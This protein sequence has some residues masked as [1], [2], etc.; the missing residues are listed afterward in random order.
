VKWPVIREVTDPAAPAVA[1]D[2]DGVTVV[3]VDKNLTGK[4]RAEAIYAALRDDDNSLGGLIL[5]PLLAYVWEPLTRWVRRNPSTA[6]VTAGVATVVTASTIVPWLLDGE[7]P[8][9]GAGPQATLIVTSA[10]AT[11]TSAALTPSPE[12]TRGAPASPTLQPTTK[13]TLQLTVRPTPLRT[14]PPTRQPSS[15]PTRVKT[16]TPRPSDTRPP[17]R[18][19]G[20]TPSRAATPSNPPR[21]TTP[22]P[23]AQPSPT[24]TAAPTPQPTLTTA[25]DDCLLEVELTPLLDLCVLS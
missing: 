3:E 11:P 12:P 5:I 10:P 2:E 21:G 23:T 4:E 18:T 8:I 1:Y 19:A 13:A 20:P 17:T 6:V 16:P 25:A 15:T 22:T 14:A 24:P 9:P 7:H